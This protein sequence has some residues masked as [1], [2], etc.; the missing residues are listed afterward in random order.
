MRR[1]PLVLK[2]GTS[3]VQSPSSP[4]GADDDG[5]GGGGGAIPRQ[6]PLVCLKGSA[7]RRLMPYCAPRVMAARLLKCVLV[8]S[9]ASANS[10]L[11]APRRHYSTDSLAPQVFTG[12]ACDCGGRAFSS[13]AFHGRVTGFSQ[14]GIVPDDAVGRRVFSG[15]LVFPAIHSGA[16][17]YSL[18]S[19]I[20]IG[21][22]DL[23]AKQSSR[24]DLS[25]VGQNDSLGYFLWGH[26]KD[27]IYQTSVEPEEELQARVMAMADLGRPGSGDRVYQNMCNMITGNKKLLNT[28]FA[29]A[30][31]SFSWE[32]VAT[33]TFVAILTS[34]RRSLL[35]KLGYLSG[36]YSDCDE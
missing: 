19:L 20:L 8:I 15:S 10:S 21:S 1:T 18:T 30:I 27:L 4:T 3:R 34:T 31:A 14:L 11:Q 36:Q 35:H 13:L 6:N 28:H 7:V 2:C 29:Y 9:C 33:L 12:P 22:Q 24:L 32:E 5:F 26:M 17:P 16:A 23:A 25:T